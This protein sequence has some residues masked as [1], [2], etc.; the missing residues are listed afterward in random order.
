[1]IKI[2]VFTHDLQKWV[3][4]FERL[5]N[6]DKI[7]KQGGGRDIVLRNELFFITIRKYINENCRGMA[8]GIIIVD[9][10]IDY[11]L[12][13]DVIKP[14]LRHG[15]S[16]IRTENYKQINIPDLLSLKI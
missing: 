16:Y 5:M 1:M 3:E 12:E 15:G 4:K 14:L 2:L 6:F 10:E 8:P 11:E 13:W 9:R 7:S